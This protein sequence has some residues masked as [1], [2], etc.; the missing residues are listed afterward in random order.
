MTDIYTKGDILLV[1][2][3]SDRAI[4]P[5]RAS[6]F[7]AGYDIYSVDHTIVPAR[8][9]ALIGTDIAIAVPSGTYGR[10]APRSGLGMICF[11][12]PKNCFKLLNSV[13]CIYRYGC[14]CN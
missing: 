1:Q 13:K 11:S 4:T 7:A 9:K 2:K 8:G 10:I 6:P 3:L 14:R 5:T 12:S